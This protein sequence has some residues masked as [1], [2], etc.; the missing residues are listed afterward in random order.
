MQIKMRYDRISKGTNTVVFVIIVPC[1]LLIMA[2][3]CSW[4]KYEGI[5]QHLHNIWKCQ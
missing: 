4:Q 1:L 3:L 5:P 2:D